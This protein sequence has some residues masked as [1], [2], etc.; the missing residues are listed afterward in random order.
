MEVEKEWN[1]TGQV[2]HSSMMKFIQILIIISPG[3]RKL[4]TE[5]VTSE[6][7]IP[8]LAAFAALNH[9]CEI[10]IYMS[11]IPAERAT[12]SYFKGAAQ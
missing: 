1:L 9:R 6:G 4:L 2:E 5:L 12:L 8:A 11:Q 3:Q 10:N 7:F